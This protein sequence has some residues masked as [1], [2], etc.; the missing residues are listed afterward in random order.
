MEIGYTMMCEQSG[1][2]ELVSDVVAAEQA[3]FDFSV[4]SD[5]Y[6]PWL[7]EQGHSPY[8]WSVLGA[9]AQATSRSPS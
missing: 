6:F 5:H 2:K 7:D 8:A 9:A 4:I 3:G 1:P